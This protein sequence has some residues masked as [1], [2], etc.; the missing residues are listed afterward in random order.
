M[1]KYVLLNISDLYQDL[2]ENSINRFQDGKDTK[3]LLKEKHADLKVKYKDLKKDF[4]YLEALHTQKL[5]PKL[6]QFKEPKVIELWVQAQ[7]A[8]FSEAELLSFK[9]GLML[10]K[11]EE[12]ST[13]EEINACHANYEQCKRLSELKEVTVNG[14]IG[15]I[16]I[17]TVSVCRKDSSMY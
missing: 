10:I 15:V 7:K 14:C 9:V 12:I 11:V 13:N 8:N 16:N 5:S 2:S 17:G 6:S 1:S 3:K 4:E